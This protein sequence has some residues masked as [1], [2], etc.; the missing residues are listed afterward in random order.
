MHRFIGT[1]LLSVALISPAVASAE[2]HHVRRYYDRDYRDW[3]EWNEHEARAY[4]RYWEER[5]EREREWAR[6]RRAQ[7]REYWRW[8]HH[9]PDAV[10]FR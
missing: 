5:R 6:L 7:Q 3:H 10:L 4:H 1:F 8:R 9:H 2:E